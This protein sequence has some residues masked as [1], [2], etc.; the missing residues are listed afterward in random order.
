MVWSRLPWAG[1]EMYY[2]VNVRKIIVTEIPVVK[3]I[4]TQS[5]LAKNMSNSMKT[6]LRCIIVPVHVTIWLVGFAC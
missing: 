5:K 6:K 2:K 4:C 1:K 3:L